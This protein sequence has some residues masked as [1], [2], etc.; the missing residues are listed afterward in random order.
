[1]GTRIQLHEKLL[2]MFGSTHVYFQPPPTINMSY[3]AI[4][5]TFAGFYERPADD[6]KY[7]T[8]E[9]YTITFI[10]KN[11]DSNYGEDMYNAFP[12]CSFDRRFVNDNLYHDV[13][14]IYY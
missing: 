9:R 7:L 3:P 11:P 10:H 1:M 12:M 6:K 13:Y 5:Y 8:E 2:A 14:T 4:V